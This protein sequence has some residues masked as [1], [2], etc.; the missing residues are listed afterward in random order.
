MKNL[1]EIKPRNLDDLFSIYNNSSKVDRLKTFKQKKLN[2]PKSEICSY[3]SP[4]TSKHSVFPSLTKKND[5][6][7]NCYLSPKYSLPLSPP[8]LPGLLGK[9]QKKNYK[10]K[11]NSLSN[12][13]NIKYLKFPKRKDLSFSQIKNKI[14]YEIKNYP[15]VINKNDQFNQKLYNHLLFLDNIVNNFSSTNSYQSAEYIINKIKYKK[16]LI[17]LPKC[18]RHNIFLQLFLDHISNQIEIRNSSN[19]LITIE[20]VYNFI[21]GEVKDLK[22][23][24][25]KSKK[26]FFDIFQDE[27]KRSISMNNKKI[28]DNEEDKEKQCKDDCP[29]KVFDGLKKNPKLKIKTGFVQNQKTFQHSKKNSDCYINETKKSRIFHQLLFSNDKTNCKG[30]YVDKN[31]SI[32]LENPD[33]I[34]Q[35]ISLIS[36]NETTLS[37][38]KQ[39]DNTKDSKVKELNSLSKEKKESVDYNNYSVITHNN[40]F[41]K[42]NV[43]DE[44]K[45]ELKS[46]LNKKESSKIKCDFMKE[47]TK[48][49]KKTVLSNF[50]ESE[51]KFDES[52]EI[53]DIKEEYYIIEDDIANSIKGNEKPKRDKLF[54]NKLILEAIH[55][56][57][58]ENFSL[59]NNSSSKETFQ[60]KISLFNQKPNESLPKKYQTEKQKDFEANKNI[61]YNTSIKENKALKAKEKEKNQ[62][63][64]KSTNKKEKKK[65][66][67]SNT[68]EKKMRQI[69]KSACFPKKFNKLIVFTENQQY[70]AKQNTIQSFSSNS[71]IF[72]ENNLNDSNQNGTQQ[73][74]KIESN[75][76]LIRSKTIKEQKINKKRSLSKIESSFK[77]KLTDSSVDSI[78][79][80]VCEK[81]FEELKEFKEEKADE[82]LNTNL[83]WDNE[84]FIYWMKKQ[85]EDN[86]KQSEG[87]RVCKKYNYSYE[88]GIL[89]VSQNIFKDKEKIQEKQIT[90]FPPE[91]LQWMKNIILMNQSIKL[92]TESRKNDNIDKEHLTINLNIEQEKK[93]DKVISHVK[94]NIRE[95]GIQTSGL[96]TTKNDIL[97]KLF[98]QVQG[99]KNVSPSEYVQKLQN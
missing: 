75:D 73:E 43:K 31:T 85:N 8:N 87:E 88:K 92:H 99:L 25:E 35:T 84:F 57:S 19:F 45:R 62:I 5:I 72:E 3:L 30:K 59:N 95:K 74:T 1:S 83:P 34:K 55:R 67:Q 56:N 20:N 36:P 17:P 79:K 33:D 65:E 49:N 4:S 94:T 93:D 14:L 66:T 69:S 52:E 89:K 90:S 96:F 2:L 44:A 22:Q 26:V 15:R 28:E 82:Y 68:K 51:N 70:E 77:N 12:L 6:K 24:V 16:S 38:I 98:N 76:D 91:F 64:K 42:V 58:I 39:D 50:K 27:N 53:S 13:F 32:I 40:K 60:N 61:V 86:T 37:N 97:V 9:Y 81:T 54:N 10:N 21:K 78:E 29:I 71:F 11:S 41:T 48:N 80:K 46:K 63:I 47:E 7:N 18:I 23:T